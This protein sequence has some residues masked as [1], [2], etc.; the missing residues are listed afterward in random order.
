MYS[1][2]KRAEPHRTPHIV[3]VGSLNMDMVVEM[4]KVP[5]KGET[6][7]GEKLH[8]LSGGK[9]ANQ[10]VAAARLGAK[11]SMI[12]AVGDD[13]FGR[14]LLAEL[15]E[16]KVDVSQVEV[17]QG[18]STGIAS[19]WLERSTGENRIAV[20]P[21]ANHRVT[22]ALLDRPETEQL[23][24]EA[25]VVL[26]QLEIP[27]AAVQKAA[28]LA[29]GA[30]ATVVLNPAPAPAG[31]LP[32]ELLAHASVLTPNVSELASLTGRSAGA[33]ADRAELSLAMGEL[34][35][36]TGC[37]VV[38]TLGSRGAA[39]TAGGPPCFA[40]AH[41]VRAVDTT[42]AGDCFSAA[43]SVALGEGAPLEGA[44]AFGTAASALAVTKLGAQSGMPLRAEVIALTSAGA[45]FSSHRPE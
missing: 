2:G 18:V 41:R 1:N 13:D 31:G 17:C 34:A 9:G 23:L 10:A 29:A 33:L 40:A 43:L 19:I 28:A 16:A 42:G 24:R 3:V 20:I 11:V 25:D 4:A 39:Y 44:V 45:K 22:P 37:A 6:L 15:Q 7:L 36:A 5:M 35:R 27:L 30:G 8:L 14:Q 12:G 32:A 38:T 21:G 26:L